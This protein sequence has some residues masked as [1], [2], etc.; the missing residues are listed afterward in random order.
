MRIAQWTPRHFAKRF[1]LKNTGN[2]TSNMKVI[3]KISF[4]FLL[5]SCLPQEEKAL[6]NVQAKFLMSDGKLVCVKKKESCN[7]CQLISIA[8]VSFGWACT[9]MGCP[10]EPEKPLIEK[11]LKSVPKAD[12]CAD[13]TKFIAK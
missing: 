12:F 1:A 10:T 11:C 8:G 9:E 13:P 7:S 3:L 5:A 2:Y 6:C 4:L